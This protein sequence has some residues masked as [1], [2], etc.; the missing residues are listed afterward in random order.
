[1]QSQSTRRRGPRPVHIL[2][3]LVALGV[4]GV[5]VEHFLPQPAAAPP[6]ESANAY[7][8]WSTC[9]EAVRAGLKAP[10]SADFPAYDEHATSNS[11]TLWVVKS[12]VDADNSFG[13]HIRT[14]YECVAHHAGDRWTVDSVKTT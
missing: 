7:A 9:R 4:V 6:P 14:R 2:L 13:A 11:G 10:S 12:Y 8:A 3:G 1:M 5:A